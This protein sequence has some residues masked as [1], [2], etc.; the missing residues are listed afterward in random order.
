MR[1]FFVWGLFTFMRLQ[2]LRQRHALDFRG[3]TAEVK[4]VL[5]FSLLFV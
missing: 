2:K 3:Y 5:G 4:F 1:V